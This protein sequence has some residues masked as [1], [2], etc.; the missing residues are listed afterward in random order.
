MKS[1]LLGIVF[2][3]VVAIGGLLYRNVV[4]TTTRPVVCPLDAKRCPDGTSVS[5]EGISCVFPECPPP[6]VSLTDLGLAYAIPPGF[7]EVSP[8][9]TSALKEYVATSSEAGARIVLR[10]YPLV[11]STSPID[12]IRKTAIG[13]ASGLPVNEKSLTSTSLGER[14]YTLASLERFEGQ[15]NTAYYLVRARDLIRFDAID[16]GVSNWTDPSL[17]TAKLPAHRALV[18]LLTTLEAR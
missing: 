12:L 4:E 11:A 14:R 10:Q 1:L 9:D 3:V 15:I 16:S 17:D 2:I 6:N 13:G 7:V 5:R 18:R 8:S